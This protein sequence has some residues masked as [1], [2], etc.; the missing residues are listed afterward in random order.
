LSLHLINPLSDNRWDDLVARHPRAS[1]FHRRGW[2][3]SL[4]RTY[5]YEPLVLTSAAPSQP[6]NDGIVLC[7]VSSWMTGTRLVSLPF[8]DH[9][10]PL[11]TDLAQVP[12]FFHR[13]RVESDRQ[14]CRYIEL[15]PMGQ[16]EDA[17][18]GFQ[19]SGSYCFHALDLGP[20][21]EQIFAALHKDSIQR[22]IRRADREQLSYE[23]GRSQ[24]LVD[25]FYRLLL[26]TRRR[27]QLLPQPR[28]WFRNLVA[29]MGDAIQIGLARKNGVPIAAMLTLRHRS[30]V[31]YKYGCSAEEFHPLGGMPFLFWR[32]IEESKAAGAEE[33]DFGRSDLDNEGL[34]VFKD[35]FGARRKSLTY[36]RYTNEKDTAAAINWNSQTVRRF[37]AV[38]PDVVFSTAGRV[39]YRHM[40]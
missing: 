18:S 13:L 2:I 10:H 9:C 6:L 3:E 40:G 32:L 22:K 34:V 26:I 7:R 33:V 31:V 8:S 25:E 23:T 16:I 20:S 35:R 24:E 5:G 12:E 38:L 39:M 4:V 15:R 14:S 36:F 30:T 1:A 28:I 29:C 37:L 27:H 21:L 17:D 11:L 19:E